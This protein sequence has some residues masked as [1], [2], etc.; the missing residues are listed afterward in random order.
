MFPASKA[1]ASGVPGDLRTIVRQ[2]R[3]GARNVT[4]CTR[5]AVPGTAERP[6][7]GF[8]VLVAAEPVREAVRDWLRLRVE[9][10][11]HPF[12]ST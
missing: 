10:R 3:T 11:F 6:L 4:L 8:F 2:F 9:R 1:W 12:R 7:A 5:C